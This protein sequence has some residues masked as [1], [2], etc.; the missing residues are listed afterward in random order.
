MAQCISV[1]E[2]IFYML[3]CFPG[4]F[5]VYKKKDDFFRCF[6]FV[7]VCVSTCVTFKMFCLP[8]FGR[9]LFDVSI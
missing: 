4:P 6:V 9:V 5:S 8:M 3:M 1:E 2:F 7:Y